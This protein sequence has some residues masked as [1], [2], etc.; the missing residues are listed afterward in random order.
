MLRRAPRDQNPVLGRP[1]DAVAGARV[2]AARGPSLTNPQD[3]R[4][5]TTPAFRGGV[6]SAVDAGE[7]DPENASHSRYLHVIDWS[8]PCRTA[9]KAN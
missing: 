7:F 2:L 1:R 8:T 4:Q 9:G 6:G 3:V 5:G